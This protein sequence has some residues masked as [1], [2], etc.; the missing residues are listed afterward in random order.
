MKKLLALAALLI[1]VALPFAAASAQTIACTVTWTE[2]EINSANAIL[3]PG[4][5]R[6]SDPVVDLQPGQVQVNFT[7]SIRVP[8]EGLVTYPISAVLVPT[9]EDGRVLWSVTST[10]VGGSTLDAAMIERIND[11]IALSWGRYLRMHLGRGTVTSIS[12][13]DTELIVVYSGNRPS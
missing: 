7:L 4:F 1:V 11:A 9:L 12:I 13:T 2:A 5:R 8:R 3:I 6:I 10:T